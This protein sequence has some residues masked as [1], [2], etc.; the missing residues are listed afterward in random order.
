MC[1]Q[2]T[3]SAGLA[4]K[5]LNT[6]TCQEFDANPHSFSDVEESG[7]NGTLEER[8][9][10]HRKREEKTGQWHNNGLQVPKESPFPRTAEKR[11]ESI[12]KH[13]AL[14][15]PVRKPTF[16]S[17]LVIPNLFGLVL[18]CFCLFFMTEF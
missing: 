2:E 5:H 18:P 1:R 12:L 11:E 13:E 3:A 10:D 7:G 8:V 15:L 16:L 17:T 4:A 6:V 14:R 9:S